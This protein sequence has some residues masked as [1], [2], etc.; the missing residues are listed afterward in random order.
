MF[1]F[2]IESNDATGKYEVCLNII[3]LAG[4][5]ELNVKIKIYKGIKYTDKL[6]NV[7]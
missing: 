7:Q 4:V 5:T 2:T 6:E 3:Y 1:T